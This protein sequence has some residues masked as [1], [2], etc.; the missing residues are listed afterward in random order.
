M[1]HIISDGWSLGIFLREI[2]KAAYLATRRQK[3]RQPALPGR[4]QVQYADFAGMASRAVQIERRLARKTSLEFLEKRNSMVRLRRSQLPAEQLRL[5][6]FQTGQK[7]GSCE[8][9]WL[10]APL[11]YRPFNNLAGREWHYARFA[12]LDDRPGPSRLRKMDGTTGHGHWHGCVAGR[13]RPRTGECDWLFH[14]LPAAPNPHSGHRD[15]ARR[16]SC[17]GASHGGGKR[18]IIRNCP[19]EKMVEA[20]QSRGES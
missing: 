12:V 5:R 6:T 7:R 1:H 16:N 18:K 19:F 17:R 10:S 4:C 3:S 2:L 14:E 9:G 11:A 15:W 8:P 13:N 20:D